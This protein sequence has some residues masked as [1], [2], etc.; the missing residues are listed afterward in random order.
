MTSALL[1]AVF[2]LC[3]SSGASDPPAAARNVVMIVA[4]DHGCDTGAYGN[5]EVR[6]P[7]LDALAAQGTRFTHA[8]ATTASCSASRSVILTGFQNHRTG[9]YGH[10]HHFHHFASFDHLRSLPRILADAGYHTARVGKYHVAPEE[11]Y[12]FETVIRASARNP[13][14]MAER[15]REVLFAEDERPFFLYFATSDPHRS[16]KPSGNTTSVE[17][18]DR[19]GNRAQPYPGVTPELYNPTKLSVPAWLPD[20]A[21]TR[22]ELAQYYQ[23]VSRVDQ[24]VG[25]LL[26]LLDEAGKAD[27]TLVLYLS[28]HGAAFAGAK[29]SVYEP[30]LRSPLIVRH[31]DAK[32]GV[33]HRAMV[34][35]VDLTPTILDWA[36]VESP[37][38]R[39]AERAPLSRQAQPEGLHG[40]SFLS[41]LDQPDAQGWDEIY[42]SHTFHEITMY[43]P[44]RVVRERQYKLIWNLA[45]GLPYPFAT[46]LWI[47]STWQQS[48]QEGLDAR[49]GGRTVQQ[50]LHRPKYELYD[51]RADPLE[52]N[53]LASDPEHA[54]TLARL[55]EKL[56]R[57]QDETSD[58]WR[59]KQIYE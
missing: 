40:R 23:S 1:A 19:F 8:F 6:T 39:G 9:Q 10:Q 28:D 35:W 2:A 43:Y 12:P 45:H 26:Q 22:A 34:S 50:F 31:P 29:T 59:V 49:Y 21:V 51:L 57:F 58:P 3:A 52:S 32:P 46:D 37:V 17:E 41:I 38:L 27:S 14:E 56:H 48:Y 5:T 42:A 13:V 20:T 16:S 53:N 33:V 25:A 44:M 55:I 36:Q 47:S 18:S 15:C 24:G 30:G 7:H 11:V 4:D 54:Q